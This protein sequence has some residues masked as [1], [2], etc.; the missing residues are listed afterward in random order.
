MADLPWNQLRYGELMQA[1]RLLSTQVTQYNVAVTLALVTLLGFA[2]DR[3]SWQLAA[4]GVALEAL[5][6]FIIEVD[7]RASPDRSARQRRGNAKRGRVHDR[8]DARARCPADEGVPAP[9]GQFALI[10]A[11]ACHV[12]LVCYFA[13]GQNWS[14]AGGAATT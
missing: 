11:M 5:M 4:L 12:G 13:L 3:E 14:F 9:R 8:G 2:I 7:R 1:Y 6:F 10:V